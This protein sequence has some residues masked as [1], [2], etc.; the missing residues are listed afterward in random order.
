[1]ADELLPCPFCGNEA[2]LLFIGNS[3][4]KSR[5]AEIK[6]K[7]CYVKIINAGLRHGS[8]WVAKHSIDDWNK[9]ATLQSKPVSEDSIENAGVIAVGLSEELP[10]ELTA[11][12][13]SFFI[14]GFQE[15][16]KYYKLTLQS[17]QGDT[18]TEKLNKVRDIINNTVGIHEDDVDKVKAY[19]EP[20]DV[21][22][23][24][25]SI[26]RMLSKYPTLPTPTAG[27]IKDILYDKLIACFG[28]LDF[29]TPVIEGHDKT[30]QAIHDLLNKTKEEN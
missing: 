13:Q 15:C 12:E 4:T 14:A 21:L 26:I 17:K 25:H 28:G 1:M 19:H 9:R 18:L 30:A 16:V 7:K 22:M 10:D 5:K 8:E 2:E 20:S 3:H 24:A 29:D 11:Q 6:C 27:E 23:A